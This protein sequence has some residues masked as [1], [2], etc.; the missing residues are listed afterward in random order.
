MG[1]VPAPKV[2][3]F[4]PHNYNTLDSSHPIHPLP[5]LLKNITVFFN[6]TT[7]MPYKI[8]QRQLTS[9]DIYTITSELQ[10][11][12]GCQI[13]KIY[14]LSRSEILIRIKNIENKEKYQLFIRNNE[15]ICLTDKDFKKPTNP[16]TFAMTLRKY[17]QNGRITD[18]QQH[19][20]D[21]IIKIKVGKKEG[22]YTLVLEFF[23]DGNII[24]VDPDGKIIIPMIRQTWKDRRVKGREV[25]SPPPSQ[26]NPFNLSFE[27][28]KKIIMGSDTDLVRT[29]AVNINLSGVIAEEICIR[30]DVDKKIKIKDIDEADLKEIFDSLNKFLKIFK[31]KEISPVLV[32]KEGENIDILPFKFKSYTNVD[33]ENISSMINGL[34]EFIEYKKAE[35]KVEKPI[36]KNVGRLERQMNQQQNAIEKLKEEIESKKVEGDIIYLNYQ[37]IEKLL[38]DIKKV[39][40]QKDK[41]Q[42]IEEINKKD[43]VKIFEPTKKLLVLNL[44]DTANKIFEVKISFKM[45]VAENAKKAYKDLKKLKSKLKGAEKSIDKTKSLL[46]DALKKSKEQEKRLEIDK[47]KEKEKIFWF[48][49][50]RW[51]ISSEGNIVVAGRDAKTNDIVVKKYLGENDRYAHADIHGAPSVVIKSADISG[52]EIPISDKT[53]EEACIFAASYSRAWK[54]F[55]EAQAYWV[56]PEQVSKT[57]ES[58]EFVPHGAFIIRGKRNYYRSNLETAVGLIN[59]DDVTKVMGGPVSTVKKHS[60]KYIVLVPGNIKKVDAAKKIGKVFDINS[61]IVDRVLPPGG[62]SIKESEGVKL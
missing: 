48:E 40:D 62:V 22:E 17:L 16:S 26:I 34:A 14:Q 24:L 8:M 41:K 27:E 18:I 2:L 6:N 50:F 33:F 28:F 60:D 25:Y 36:D 42:G 49:R 32:K 30:A 52:N 47:N 1:D 13:E 51:F 12:V 61:S 38:D 29:L 53:L 55:A 35:V 11:L 59:I 39:L 43:F 56:L 3:A 58:G 44:K 46:K 20:F 54:Q 9:F 57:A 37:K 15:I 19:E 31:N 23:S 5:L 10:S 45:S 7:Y 4:L 21:R